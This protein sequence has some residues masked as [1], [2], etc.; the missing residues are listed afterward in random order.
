MVDY[1]AVSQS[2][3]ASLRAKSAGVLPSIKRL[4]RNAE[5]THDIADRHPNLCLPEDRHDLF[6]G[7][8]FSFRNRTPS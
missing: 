6:R 1:F 4:L 2:L 5:L 8:P 7:E 3:K